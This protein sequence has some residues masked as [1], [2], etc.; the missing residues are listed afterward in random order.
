[1]ADCEK[2]QELISLYVDDCS[3]HTNNLSD[4]ETHELLSH[5]KTCQNCAAL[6]DDYLEISRLLKEAPE[7]PEALVSGVME[8]VRRVSADRR[9]KRKTIIRRA[10]LGIAAL[11]ACAAVALVPRAISDKA[12]DA[13][14]NV[15]VTSGSV[16]IE[17][18]S[19]ESYAVEDSDGFGDENLAAAESGGAECALDEPESAD[20]GD[21]DMSP[22]EDV[23]DNLKDVSVYSGSGA[24]SGESE[25]TAT[26]S[27]YPGLD[28]QYVRAD[29]DY[30]VS[31]STCIIQSKAELDNYYDENSENYDFQASYCTENYSTTSFDD[32]VISYDNEFF[33]SNELVLIVFQEDSS[34][35]CHEVV[36]VEQSGVDFT[37]T[38][39]RISPDYAYDVYIDDKAGWHIF[40]TLPAGTVDDS[41]N[42][43]VKFTE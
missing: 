13:V 20:A 11:A 12:S 9:A 27:V 35:T 24:D 22:V 38:I 15:E 23:T 7:P 28:V 29:G 36:A 25:T 32:A 19:R 4:Q 31:V 37:V 33:E 39:R 1:M 34:L 3:E 26:W 5:I 17:E 14:S 8:K 43:I 40:L 30:E 2:Y 10:S 41:D 6:L 42:L 18:N 16:Y 21:S